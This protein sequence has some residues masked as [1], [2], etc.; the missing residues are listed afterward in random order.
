MGS[1]VKPKYFCIR[2]TLVS[3]LLMGLAVRLRRGTGKPDRLDT[4]AESYLH[5]P[6]LGLFS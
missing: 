2:K 6:Y 4:G 5:R 1:S 3:A